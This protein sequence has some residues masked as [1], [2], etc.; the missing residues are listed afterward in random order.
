MPLDSW[1]VTQENNFSCLCLLWKSFGVYLGHIHGRLSWVVPFVITSVF[2]PLGL[3]HFPYQN[4]LFPSQV[5]G[6]MSQW[7]GSHLVIQANLELL[8]GPESPRERRWNLGFLG[9]SLSLCEALQGFLDAGA[10]EWVFPGKVWFPN[11]WTPVSESIWLLTRM[12]SSWWHLC[13]IWCALLAVSCLGMRRVSGE[14]WL[15]V[16]SKKVTEISK[17]R[18]IV[19]F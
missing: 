9:L 15:M 16:T 8:H 19:D 18:M 11:Q 13:H 7:W 2:G 6:V 4:S 10:C 12:H 17:Y 5:C 14:V 1:M 3:R